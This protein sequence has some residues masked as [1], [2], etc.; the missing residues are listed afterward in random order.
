MR[1]RS[2][3]GVRSSESHDSIAEVAFNLPLERTFHYLVPAHLNHAAQRGVRV[4]APFG[5][6]ERVGFILQRVDESPI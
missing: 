1:R 5:P 3:F 6:R 4:A 2:E